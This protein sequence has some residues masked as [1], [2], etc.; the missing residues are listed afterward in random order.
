MCPP[1]FL[2]LLALFIEA[3]GTIDQLKN[4]TSRSW[5]F[6]EGQH[7]RDVIQP[8]RYADINMGVTLVRYCLS[9][10]ALVVLTYVNVDVDLCQ[11]CT[12]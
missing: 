11:I 12:G 1:Y 9:E 8:C 3:A 5:S 7:G 2:W 4:K 10:H 6:R